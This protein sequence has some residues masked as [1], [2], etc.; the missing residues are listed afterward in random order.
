[1]LRHLTN[2][3]LNPFFQALVIAGSILLF[4]P[5]GIQKYYARQVDMITY[6]DDSKCYFGDLDQDGISQKVQTFYSDAKNASMVIITQNNPYQQ[7]NFKGKFNDLS[8]RFMLGDYNNNQIQEVYL[9]TLNDDS[10]FLQA[11]EY[12]QAP[13]NFIKNRFITRI[14]RNL[15]DPDYLFLPGK[16]ADMNGDGFG[17]LVFAINAGFSR[18]PRRVFIYNIAN[19]SLKVSPEYGAF[20]GDIYIA[21]LDQDSYDE[22]ILDTYAAD[23]LN[24]TPA[25]YSDSSSW[26]MVLDDNLEFLFPPQEFHGPA[27]DVRAFPISWDG[28]RVDGLVGNAKYI[29]EG[30]WKKMLFIAD[31]NGNIVLS[32]EY[33]DTKDW[34]SFNFVPSFKG[35][36]NNNILLVNE[37]S[38]F[39]SLNKDLDYKLIKRMNLSIR[40]PEF[41]DIDQDQQ[42]EILVL[43][44][45]QSKYK[46]Y[47]SDFSNPV[48]IDFPIQRRRPLLSVKLNGPDPPQL[49]V[50]G[51]QVWKLFDYGINPLWNLRFL[52]WA[53]IYAA[54]LGFVMVIRKLYSFQLKK[55]YETEKKIARLQ[56][57]SVKA[58]MEPHFIMN[59]INTI[60]SSIYRQKPDEAY[61]HLVNFSGMVRSL[62]VSSDKLTR[63]L[64]E[65]LEFVKN[66]LEL[67]KSRFEGVFSYTVKVAENI[68]QESLIPKMIIQLHTE[69]ALKHGLL[70]KKSGG[71]LEID[72]ES[73]PDYIDISIKDNG[74]GRS[75][76]AKA[77]TFSTGKGMKIMA[78]LFETYNRHNPK[79]ISQEIIDL[80]DNEGDAAGTMVKI[81]IPIKFNFE[82]Y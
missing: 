64:G 72:I 52:I 24:D 35:L 32:K 34:P 81:R 70:P 41:I 48:E 71:L 73:E 43:S 39:Y 69:N 17:D 12:G 80:T 20:I 50:Q 21:N 54:V 57:A 51:D 42:D 29:S 6:F 68:N 45:D 47:R 79:P 65:E 16:V 13:K 63:T 76:A 2:I 15:K 62:L 55:R 66:Y 49:S 30:L 22:I 56:L 77:Q 59:T 26:L 44:E 23:N 4:V 74:I 7:W 8:P 28:V 10:V 33:G 1:M 53:G 38:G 3:I 67:E 78:Q 37:L 61:Q 19:D 40:P 46:I 18:Y 58:Q 75:S 27:G 36:N 11:V 5:F 60:G 14:G 31:L 25:N 82:I 9:F